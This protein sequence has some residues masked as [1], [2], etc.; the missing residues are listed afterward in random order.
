MPDLELRLD[1]DAIAELL[2]QVFPQV[3]EAFSIARV[4]PGG[5]VVTLDPTT[6]HL[7]PGDT[8]S[9]PAMFTVADLAFY[10]ATLGLIGAEPLTVTTHAS[11]DFMRKP[12]PGRLTGRATIHKLGRTLS[13]GQVLLY[14]Q[15]IDGPVA[16]VALT[17]AI[18]PRPGASR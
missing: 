9:G 13:V 3:G 14:S 2:R 11:I 5:A 16:Q 4:T 10:V 1:R 15:G 17:Y 12:G 8:V 18:P 7:R 6:E